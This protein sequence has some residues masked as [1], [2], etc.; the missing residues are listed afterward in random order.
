ME[1]GSLCLIGAA[2]PGN[3]TPMDKGSCNQVLAK[4]KANMSKRTDERY[5]VEAKS[6]IGRIYE[7]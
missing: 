5:D 7:G 1:E 3:G 6:Y 4:K 2:C